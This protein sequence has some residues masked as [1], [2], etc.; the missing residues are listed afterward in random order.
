[1]RCM[2]KYIRN[3]SLVLFSNG[4]GFMLSIIMS[5]VLP[6]IFDDD[7]TSYGYIQLYLLYVSYYFLFDLG[8]CNGI[9]LKEGGKD[10]SKLNYSVYSAQFLILGITQ[11]FV[12]I[13]VYCFSSFFITGIDKQF[14][15][16]VVAVNIVVMQLKTLLTSVFQATNR[17]KEY[18]V[19]IMI[20]KLFNALF[21]AAALLLGI[22]SYKIIVVLFTGGEI[23]SLVYAMVKSR[24][25][26]FCKP[27]PFV[28]VQKELKE[29]IKAGLSLLISGVSAMLITGAARL[30]I[31]HQ[32]NIEVFAKVSLTLS[33]SGMFMLFINAI[34]VVLYPE[35]RR[36]APSRY[37]PMYHRMRLFLMVFMLGALSF[38]YPMQR[39]IG[40]I[41]PQYWESATYMAI[42]LPA[43]L[44][45]GKMSMLTQTYMKVLRLEKELMKVN[46][47][48]LLVS[49]LLTA[50]TVFFFKSIHLAVFSILIS[51]IFRTLLAE[52]VL[53]KHI[54]ITPVK[55]I[56]IELTVSGMFIISNWAI[57]GISGMLLYS[58]CY[59]CY[60]LVKRSE[61]AT[62]L[63]RKS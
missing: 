46:V 5:I 8:L 16:A 33:I 51:L 29:N 1:M 14:L 11:T 10:Y 21:I 7:I 55:D 50:T 31:E 60:L 52:L 62:Y 42:L 17:I 13:L 4:I 6:L 24:R 57:G 18:S 30:A 28:I 35:M 22:R 58:V 3:F 15:F 43:C 12:G 59:V 20:C 56:V 39:L 45:S 48:S 61:I 27:A 44:Y 32:W 19:T 26:I 63:F 38:C 54:N 9:Y 34:S 23:I 47:V 36:M 49:I 37:V 53:S 41:L 2:P 40:D 25:M